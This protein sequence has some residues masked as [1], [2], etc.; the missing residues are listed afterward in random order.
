MNTLEFENDF[1]FMSTTIKVA[2]SYSRNHMPSAPYYQF[3]QTGGISTG[4]AN[5]QDVPPEQLVSKIAY[6]GAASTYL[7]NINLWSSDF[8]ENDQIYKG[9]FK[10]PVTLGSGLS[11]YIK[12]GGEYRYNY[13]MN[14]QATPYLEMRR[15]SGISQAVMDSLRANFPVYYDSSAARFPGTNFTNTDGDLNSSFLNNSFGGILWVCD[16]AMINDMLTYSY[17]GPNL[18][19]PKQNATN[20]GG[21]YDGGFQNLPNDYKYVERYYGAYAL[22]QLT[23]G[24]DFNVVGGARFEQ[25]TSL[26]ES[27]NLTDGRNPLTQQ[28]YPITVYP[29]NRFVL[30]M[31]QGKYNIV[32]WLDVRYS[33]TQTLARPDYHQL[34]PHITMSNDRLNVWAGNPDLKPAHSYNHD[35][36]FTFHDNQFGLFSVGAFYKTVREFTYYTTYKLHMSYDPVTR[37]YY[38]IPAGLDTVGSYQIGGTQPNNG[39]N[40]YTY[41]NSPNEA[42]LK[43]LEADVQTR[44]WYLPAPLN[45]IVLGINYTH[46]W[47]SAVYPWHDDRTKTDPVTRRT[48]V[49]TV[50]SSRVGR[51]IYQPN[52][53]VNAYIGYDYKGF[54]GRLSFLFQGNS[55]NGIGAF[56]EQD[57]F[58]KDYF[59]VDASARQMLPIDGLQIFLD[60]FNINSR[61]NEAAQASIGA[62]TNQQNYGMTANL[63]LR[64]TL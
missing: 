43:G 24:P 13:R 3:S 54:S 20:P 31:V 41:V 27:F 40:L 32:D 23:F 7:Y 2:N 25:V 34:S 64:Y 28:V 36:Q 29:D 46:I 63:G 4:G 56:A 39:A 52:D 47:S 5:L 49:T 59:R 19:P 33:Y 15:G 11:G 42:Y 8:K 26:F 18:M 6:K 61:Q 45:G 16:P 38:N 37:I 22:A 60:L 48:T 10:V 17:G 14:D 50:D 58:T 35:L 12:V 51:L 21:W 55:V 30:P 9:D 53:V 1:G 44:F 57:G 62:F